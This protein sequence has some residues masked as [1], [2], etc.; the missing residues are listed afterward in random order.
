MNK[1]IT[2]IFLMVLSMSAFASGNSY[3][4]KYRDQ[5]SLNTCYQQAINAQSDLMRNHVSKIRSAKGAD[6]A[7][8]KGFVENQ[9][10][11]ETQ[12]NNACTNNAVCI[13]ES[14]VSRNTWLQ[15]QRAILGV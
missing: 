15:K 8:M 12:I 6:S 10:Q 2:A 9:I 14:Q 11:W 5:R 7:Q 13:Y 4:N 1:I 3:C